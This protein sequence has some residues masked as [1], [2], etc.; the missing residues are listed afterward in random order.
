MGYIAGI[1]RE[2]L[3]LFP[4][5]LDDYISGDNPVRFIDAWV[6]TLDLAGLGFSDTV[7]AETGRPGYDP[8]AILKLYIYGYLNRI[9]SSRK[10]EQECQRNVEVMWLLGKLAPDHKTIA[11]FRKDNLTGLKETF[12]AFCLLCRELGL[13]G[14]EL[15]AVDG[16]KFKAVNSAK[17]NF[18]QTKVKE[19]LA[20][21]EQRLASYLQE[22]DQADQSE[23]S[24]LSAKATAVELQAKIERAKARQIKYQGYLKQMAERGESQ[25]SLTD[26][27][28]RA[29]PKGGV[30][31]NVQTVVDSKHHLIV[32]QEVTNEVTD[33]DQLSPMAIAAKE[34]LQV[35][36]LAAVADAGYAH[37]KELK[38]CQEAGIE[39]YVPRPDTS[40]NTKLGLFGKVQFVYDPATDT[41]TCPA[42]ET[43]AFR[44]ETIEKERQI[45]YYQTSACGK[46]P[47]KEKCT[48]NKK[49]R[50]ITRWV[51]EHIIEETQARVEAH[52]ETMKM[53]GQLVEHPFGTIKFWWD[54]GHF[55]MKGLE[56]VKAEFSLSTLA[57]NIRR[58]LNI[59]GVERLMAALS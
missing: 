41:Y 48:R 56:K 44:F 31:Y 4:E 36:R 34:M 11:D 20:E 33:R 53:R 37:G 43:L 54:H 17:R 29:M 22:L 38:A 42:A 5:S 25:L 19:Y 14:G 51:D 28:S 26:P 10:L 49:G 46:C 8:R 16:S 47:L 7:A 2:Q 58:V 23:G 57:Y 59:L 45:R 35:E 55:L 13:F 30:A 39:V 18:S 40:A 50:R 3:I 21:I 52:P 1:A 32:V 9:R 24:V 12:K 15:I 6:E 27:D